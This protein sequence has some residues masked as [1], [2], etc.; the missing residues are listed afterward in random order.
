[1][2][3]TING[4]SS[5]VKYAGYSSDGNFAQLFK[6]KVEGRGEGLIESLKGEIGE[7]KLMGI[8]HRV[9]HGGLKIQEHRVID[10]GVMGELRAAVPLDLAHLP[11]EIE[12]IEEM[13]REF[14]GVP[15]VACLD[16]AFFKE[17]PVAAKMWPIPRR[18]FEAGIRRLGFHGLSYTYL[19]G[20]LRNLGAAEGKIIL[21][22][23]GNGASMAAV[24][25]LDV[26]D[27]SMGLTPLGG[28]VMGTRPGDL[29]PGLIVHLMREENITPRKMEELLSKECGMKGIAGTSDMRELLKRQK[30]DQRASEAVETFCRQA[31]KFIGA[32]AA[33]MGGLDTLVFSG[34]IGEHAAQVRAEICAGMEFL[35]IEIDENSNE[36]N[37]AEISKRNGRVVVRVIP[38]D[39]ERVMAEIV[40]QMLPSRG[41]S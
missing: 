4:G 27:T 22:H 37:S 33:A 17:L 15:Q 2:I 13:G 40:W 16:T 38:T 30:N 32:Y 8:G 18:Y 6:G 10:E 1:M 35:G 29:D 34:G 25:D 11:G 14:A 23:L 28:L 21:A 31:K 26:V 36:R 3:L 19:M 39:E 7:K 9:V 5:T 12:L 24:S 41:R 20:V